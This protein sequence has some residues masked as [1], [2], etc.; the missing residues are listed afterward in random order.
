VRGNGVGVDGGVDDQS[1]LRAGKNLVIAHVAEI[2][3]EQTGRH[4]V[5]GNGGGPAGTG[6]AELIAVISE[7]TEQ[8]SGGFNQRN[9]GVGVKADSVGVNAAARYVTHTLR[10]YAVS[11]RPVGVADIGEGVV[12]IHEADGLIV[13]AAVHGHVNQLGHGGTG[14][15]AGGVEQCAGG[16]GAADDVEFAQDVNGPKLIR[17]YRPDVIEVGSGAGAQ[18]A[19]QGEGQYERHAQR[20]NLFEISHLGIS[21]LFFVSLIFL[22]IVRPS[23]QAE[24][25]MASSYNS[26]EKESIG[27]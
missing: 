2:I 12:G 13:N 22:L 9:V 1:G 26:R 18:A 25:L 3:G 21:S 5:G 15:C 17:G 7:H 10:P 11:V 20:E 24:R 16:V 19:H 14:Q 27:F 8:H 23:G 6:E 4:G